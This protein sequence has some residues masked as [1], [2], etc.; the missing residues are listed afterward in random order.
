MTR[1][2]KSRPSC[3]A[4]KHSISFHGSGD[5]ACRALG[6]QCVRYKGEQTLL[7]TAE[8]AQAL[9]KSQWWVREH[10]EELG[11]IRKT[12]GLRFKREVIE[13]HL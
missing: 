9:G 8:T 6:C 4:C 2:K 12:I 13:S 10:A 7:T 3:K 11:V 1:K 5:T